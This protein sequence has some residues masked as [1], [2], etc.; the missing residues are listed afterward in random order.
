MVVAAGAAIAAGYVAYKVAAYSAQLAEEGLTI[1]R[2]A[3][4][5]AQTALNAVMNMN[6]YVLLATGI[7]ALATG[8]IV[9]SQ[10]LYNSQLG[11]NVLNEEEKKK[12]SCDDDVR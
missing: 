10:E 12:T 4:T 7:A 2:V 1:A 5:A 9:Y 3:A 8:L 6:P 11:V